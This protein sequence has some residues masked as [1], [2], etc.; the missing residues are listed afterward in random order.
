MRVWY[1]LPT[2]GSGKVNRIIA[3][4]VRFLAVAIALGGALLAQ[5]AQAAPHK[6][7]EPCMSK[8]LEALVMP[9]ERSVRSLFKLGVKAEGMLV[10][11]VKP[12]GNA[13]IAGLCRACCAI[14]SSAD[15]I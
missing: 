12:V 5:A 4:S 9:V 1:F 6:L 10:L 3:R 7:P 2:H 11:A 8:A 15:Y 13:A 14:K